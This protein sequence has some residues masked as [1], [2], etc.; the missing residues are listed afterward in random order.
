MNIYLPSIL[1]C[2][3]LIGM[4]QQIVTPDSYQS[5]I[6]D[7]ERLNGADSALMLHYT[8]KQHN[9]ESYFSLTHPHSRLSYNSGYARGYNDGAV[10]KGRGMN[11]EVHAGFSGT[12]GILSY[13]FQPVFFYAQNKDYDLAPQL[14][15][16]INPYNY[17][18]SNSIDW[19][20]Q[21]GNTSYLRVHPGQSTIKIAYEGFALSASTENYIYG[22]AVYNPLILG[23]NA[24]GIPKINI[25]TDG[26]INLGYKKIQLGSFEGNMIHGL[27]QESPYFDDDSDNDWR[28]FTALFLGYSPKF[29]PNLSIGFNKV[30]YK[31]TQFWDEADVYSTIHI[32]DEP[33]KI[34][35]GD[36]LHSGNDFFDQ[37]ASITLDWKFPSIGFRAYGEFARNDFNGNFRRFIV[38]PEYS[39]AFLVGFQ[40]LIRLKRAQMVINYEHSNI[41]RNHSFRLRP[42]PPYYIHGIN[43]Q[44]YTNQGQIMAAGIGP[45]G[46]AD[47][48]ALKFKKTGTVFGFSVQ[49]I[50]F[51]KDYFV[52]NVADYN[53]HDI[54]YTFG[55][56]FHK[57]F[58][59]FILGVESAYSYNLNKYYGVDND[60]MNFYLGLNTQIKI[61]N[62]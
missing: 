4:A 61:S 27:M 43:K 8:I 23:E 10:W 22:P 44:G 59:R 25:G 17:Q 62:E 3:T 39:R 40:K 24:P 45:G 41:S 37:L 52:V 49:R 51:N 26:P 12:A 58:N 53:K 35:N 54:E 21:Y 55:G 34:V 2:V 16:N 5:Y 46:N 29:A 19:V 36:T 7:F 33:L 31:Q 42:N 1:S 6:W 57:D 28:Y 47:V 9:E 48:V 15:P 56:N 32:K 50:E 18:F 60:K 20:Q 11:A 38:E 14:N 30:L 13:T